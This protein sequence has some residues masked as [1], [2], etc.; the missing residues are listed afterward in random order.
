MCERMMREDNTEN[1]REA[2]REKKKAMF[3]KI[4]S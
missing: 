4:E 3:R 1:S 2:I